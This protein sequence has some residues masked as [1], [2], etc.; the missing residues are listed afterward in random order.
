MIS[1]RNDA[2]NATFNDNRRVSLVRGQGFKIEGTIKAPD[3]EVPWVHTCNAAN[4][5]QRG[6]ALTALKTFCRQNGVE[7][8][9]DELLELEIELIKIGQEQVGAPAAKKD[10][11]WSPSSEQLREAER[12]LTRPDLLAVIVDAVAEKGVV[13][14][15]EL[16]ALAYLCANSRLARRPAYLLVRGSFSSGKSFIPETVCDLFPP[17]VV[18]KVTSLTCNS[19]Y[20]ISETIGDLRYSVLLLGE[21]E[22]QIKPESVDATKAL[23]ELQESGRISKLVPIRIGD[24]HKSV[25]LKLE[26]APA[27]IQSVSHNYIAAEDLSRAIEVFTDESSAQTREVI[28]EAARRHS[29]EPPPEDEDRYQVFWALQTVL[30]PVRVVIPQLPSLAE[31]FPDTKPEARRAFMRVITLIESLAIL[32]QR[33]RPRRSDIIYA[34]DDDVRLAVRLLRPWLQSRLLDGPPSTALKVWQIIKDNPSIRSQRDLVAAGVASRP[35]IREALRYLE[36]AGALRFIDENE[37]GGRNR[38]RMF[39]VIDPDWTPPELNLCD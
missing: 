17:G 5:T 10:D 4:A 25:L 8:S 37:A 13:G 23:R 12:L 2:A 29:V 30:E 22:R 39:E 28:R 36:Q 16:S 34:D 32:H 38:S 31:R 35:S 27:V 19:L 11:N 21:R 1:A 33:Q 6:K 9:T 14:E 24:E 18:H 7:L 3:R 26:G 20:Y 15:R